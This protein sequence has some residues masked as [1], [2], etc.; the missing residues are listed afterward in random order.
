MFAR[1]FFGTWGGTNLFCFTCMRSEVPGKQRS[2]LFFMSGCFFF[3][4]GHFWAWIYFCCA[5][6]A[7]WFSRGFVCVCLQDGW[8]GLSHCALKERKTTVKTLL[9]V[10]FS[11]FTSCLICK[12]MLV[13]INVFLNTI[14]TCFLV[15][16]TYYLFLLIFFFVFNFHFTSVS[17]L[18]FVFA[19]ANP[20]TDRFRTEFLQRSQIDSKYRFSDTYWHKNTRA[21]YVCL[22]GNFFAWIWHL[23]S[24][25][26]NLLVLILNNWLFIL[27][28]LLLLYFWIQKY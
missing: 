8:P 27:L 15:C 20:F 19:A 1:R 2:W 18:G 17:W 11:F 16:L 7:N 13:Y 9:H 28:L 5:A 26:V 3:G 12:S 10:V 14:V 22:F 21:F 24:L 4:G 23:L 25:S 6:C